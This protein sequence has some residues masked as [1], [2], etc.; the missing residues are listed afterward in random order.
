MTKT[1]RKGMAGS[2]AILL[3]FC[4]CFM[5]GVGLAAAAPS[6][7]V[8]PQ[9][10]EYDAGDTFQVS[11]MVDSETANLRGVN[12][13]LAYDPS[14][15]VVNDVTNEELF[16]TDTLTIS[17]GDDGAGTIACGIAST[18]GTYTPEAGTMLT[19]DFEVKAG[20]ANGTY[21]L[22]L[23]GVV[24]KDEA[25][26]PIVGVGVTDGTLKVG[27][28]V[29]V[30]TPDE[31]EVKITPATSGPV[32]PGDTFVVEVEVDSADENLRGVNLQLAY[33][34]A[35][36]M[37]NDVTNDELFGSDTLTISCGDDG[38]GTI[39]CGIASTA[40]TY[41]PEAG[42]MLTIEFEVKAGATDGTYDLDLNTVVLKDETNTAIAGVSVT[43]AT[44]QVADGVVSDVPEVIISP[45]TSG[46]VDI[47][48]TFLVEVDVDSADENLRGVNLQLS[49]DPAVLMVNDVIN[50]DLLGAGALV[51][52]GSGD[53]AAGTISYGL[54]ATGG[55]YTP[56]AGTMLT[57]E[58]EVKAGATDGTY[59]LDLNAVVLKDESNTAIA[60]VVV[61]DGTV[62][63]VT[64]PNVVPVPEI[65]SHSD[66]DVVSKTQIV[67]VVDNSSQDD[68]ITATFAIFADT[69]GNCADDD[70]GEVWTEFA[71]DNDS[72]DGWTAVLDT[73]SVP[74]G[75]YLIKAT[76][77]DGTDSAFNIVCV[78][79][80]NPQGIILLPGWNLI[81]V[82]ETLENATIDYVLQ[83]FTDVEVDDVFYDNGT[84]MI[85]PTTFEPLK[86]YWVH[87][88]LSEEVVILEDYFTP[89]VPSTPPSLTLY[90]GW[91][92]IGHNAKVELSAEISL[93][94][95]DDCYF[96]V[97][98]PWV[99]SANEFAY[100]GNN[101]QEGPLNGN[102]I[103]TDVFEMNMY[104][105]YY[106]FVNEECVLA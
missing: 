15:L 42:T 94:T 20:A 87:N 74:D 84:A 27:D 54:A 24:L 82:P 88:N 33:D 43:D 105:G 30:P 65:I 35:V 100:V 21:D 29:V 48:D 31:P 49:Y 6:V 28:D 37:V 104:E 77:D 76:L 8:D 91:N 55:V 2:T 59:D 62:E 14:V 70:V 86:A 96:K 16:G 50:E 25:N 92:A 5:V 34:P 58:F 80:Y 41:T 97:I 46:P 10:N 13:Q 83:D 101:G 89:K 12:L 11:V 68:I 44:V 9:T 93:A 4:A 39:A 103:G 90:P 23:N 57:I 71:T 17:C 72:S 52:P 18:A 99:T 38:A 22:D 75:K 67:E 81:S 79:V 60:G 7:S 26:E 45:V 56:E 85:V 63:I 73:T 3:I 36:L 66:G 53:D 98:G 47:G 40:G 78:A 61:T 19:V 95:I 51:A 106:V 69:N 32:G 64:V 102:Q 1:T